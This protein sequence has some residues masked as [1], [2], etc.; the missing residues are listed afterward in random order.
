MN[1][2]P[3]RSWWPVL[4]LAGVL[5]AGAGC[6]GGGGGGGG[7]DSGG[8]P[9]GGGGGP[10]GGASFAGFSFRT[11]PTSSPTE[12]TT[13]PL[14]DLSASPPKIGAPL[15]IVVIF[16][17]DPSDAAP[18][19]PFTSTSLP[20]FTTPSQMPPE[21]IPPNSG[22]QVPAKGTYVHVDSHT[23]E[24]HPFLPQEP[25]STN[26]ASPPDSIPG[27][28][29]GAVYTAKVETTPGLKI[30]NLVG[31]G[32]SVQFGITT[33]PGG[34]FS[35]VSDDDPPS[36]VSSVPG[37]GAADFYPGLFSNV[38]AG[39]D[40]PTFQPQGPA[41]IDLVYDHG[42]EPSEEN[43]EGKD[44]N[45]DG[46][47]DATFFLRTRA[48][49]LLVSHTVP[50][51][52]FNGGE[53]AFAA[54]SDLVE[55][56]QAPALVV[57]QN[58]LD[59][60]MH[61][62]TGPFAGGGQDP[63][64]VSAPVALA[65]GPDPAL[66]FAIFGAP[67]NDSLTVIDHTLGENADV[68]RI[69][70]TAK[71]VPLDDAVGLTALLD[72]R[73]VAFDRT[74]H[75][76]V[77]LQ[78]VVTRSLPLGA[79]TLVSVGTGFTSAAFPALDVRDLA[80]SPSGALFALTVSGGGSSLVPLTPI[81][82][83]LDDSFEP[84]DGLPSG[85]AA[86]PL[87]AA[88]PYEAFEFLTETTG[89]ALQRED[90]AV[91]RIDLTTGFAQRV[92]SNL[93]GFGMLDPG[94]PSPAR[95]IAV[96]HMSLDLDVDLV[97]NQ[98]QRSEFLLDP[99]SVLPSS[100]PFDLMQR[101]NLASLGGISEAN[102]DIAAPLYVLGARRLLSFQTAD[103]ANTRGDCGVP[104]PENRVHDVLQE[105]FVDQTLEDPEPSSLSPLA[106][107]GGPVPGS[108]T[109]GLLTAAAG[110]AGGV[111]L[112]DFLPLP[113]PK[114]IGDPPINP[115]CFNPDDG[116]STSV[117]AV[118]NADWR[119]I[120][121][122]T[123][124][125]H[126][127]L[128][129]GS[130][131]GVIADTTVVGGKF[132]F[133]DVIIPEGVWI[134]AR[135]SKPLQ[136]TAT[137][138]VEIAGLIDASGT[139]GLDDSTF[140]T[141][142]LPVPGGKGGPG[143]GR[144]G[145]AQPTMWN[146]ALPALIQIF[147]GQQAAQYVTPEKAEDG[148]GPVLGPTGQVNFAP[149][150]GRGGLSTLGYNPNSS[151]FTIL[152][153]G[154][155]NS[156]Y[157]RPPGGGGGSYYVPGEQA[158]TGS[159]SYR[160]QSNS[161][162]APF[163]Q[164][165]FQDWRRDAI[166][167]NEEI[168]LSPLLYGVPSLQCVY[169]QGTLD[170]PV[171][172]Q[173]GGLA[174]NAVFVD[175]DPS[176]DFI[177]PGGELPVLIGGQGG[178]G[179]GTR[180]DSFNAAIWACGSRTAQ[181][182]QAPN[183]HYIPLAFNNIYWSP[184]LFDAKGGGG[185]GGGGAVL[186]RSFGDIRLTRMGHI[187]AS[188]GGGQGGE[189]IGNSNYSGGGGGGSGGAIVLQAGGDIILEADANHVT[190]G[191]VDSTLAQGAALDVSGGF[192]FDATEDP[193]DT[194]AAPK[195]EHTVTRSDGGNGGF[196]LIQLQTG[197]PTGAPRIEQGAFLFARQQVQYKKGGWND[198]KNV[199]QRE[200]LSWPDGGGGPVNDLRYIDMMETRLF[201]YETEAQTPEPADFWWYVL[202]GSD[203]PLITPESGG[204]FSPLQLDTVMM[205]HYGRR[206]VRE[207][208][209]EMLMAT[210][211]GY[212]ALTFKESNWCLACSPKKY[213]D[214]PP[215]TTY[216]PT[217]VIPLSKFVKRP[218]GTP[219]KEDPTDTNPFAEFAH[220]STIEKLPV[221]PLFKP[222]PAIG[223]VSRGTSKWLDF[224]GVTL[225]QRDAT[226]LTP[227]LFPGLQGTYNAL[228]GAPPPGKEALVVLGSPLSGAPG[229]T[230]AHLVANTGPFP[231]DPGLCPDADP[232]GS[233]PPFNDIK[234]DSPDYGLENVITDN[235]TVALEFQGAFPVR[236][237]SHVPDS[238]TLSNW[239]SDVR[240]LSGYPLVRFRVTFDLG[241]NPNFPFEPD[242]K[243][244]GVDRVRLRVEY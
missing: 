3:R 111:S 19:G 137:G 104:D 106:D 198:G 7:G 226:G 81:D 94:D 192:G 117:G 107:W 54:L 165:K 30:S 26:P 200:H 156:E 113:H 120:F 118:N 99:P 8:T 119:I 49:R 236:A 46:L 164:C 151:G 98:P 15:D 78:P 116:Y 203:P 240:S 50:A 218:D 230:P 159:G 235:A 177:G 80:Q 75:K 139:D 219:L 101:P 212:D 157:H 51:G 134:M 103:P 152:N 211:F 102:A 23:V 4:L 24:F 127:P 185:G 187:D 163:T 234:V 34:F 41:T 58:G 40:E 88:G 32:G 89:L 135:G 175:G 57:N 73:L 114:C 233:G 70:A 53:P 213:L 169:L 145:D 191:F 142:F 82:F 181:P 133:H 36:L 35:N 28:I 222:P 115:P 189:I 242:S 170:N 228:L 154:G 92:V 42:V 100:T 195:D 224:N 176:N 55:S 25:L 231:F 13:P 109:S 227:P 214:N 161:T 27:F 77:E 150:G 201:E 146:P 148:I 43:L 18:A 17:F 61:D 210:Y 31:A 232:Q 136:I 140:D 147:N 239:V 217:D 204:P 220:S 83:D 174:G 141:G 194:A 65:A 79:P 153:N 144:G 155:D 190:P 85:A 205:D 10:T 244:P 186:I 215:G 128:P 29:P 12:F 56:A 138:R 171:R 131:P 108:Q 11:G 48:S 208:H 193:R 91:D 173:P 93:A 229:D 238:A 207:P 67:G 130:T 183:P 225:G 125:Q 6:G 9:I 105:E 110:D 132:N 243:T 221:V 71:T 69:A 206:V 90:D 216:A 21:A 223:A 64:L 72:G 76:I 63:A 74:A 2:R 86:I 96:A 179:G 178:G 84:G 37:D 122:D 62:S 33:L 168:Q 95:A 172:F 14:E 180:V 52:T 112:G 124:V 166:Y 39:G 5:V 44:W 162:W 202:N 38:P 149:I 97:D 1:A 158:P 182:C 197:G 184:Q 199:D 22:A 241:V 126:F 167:G 16:H 143:G 59:I 68:A 45:G 160:V 20:V 87:P 129:D 237:G 121:L 47:V 196:G 60:F 188:G 209:P 123:D 66:T